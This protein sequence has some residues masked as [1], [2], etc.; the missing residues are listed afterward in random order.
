[1]PSIVQ[2][3]ELRTSIRTKARQLNPNGFAS[4]SD[5]DALI[6]EGAY[7]LYNLLVR[8]R[9]PEYFSEQWATNTTTGAADTDYVLP[10]DFFQ[11]VAIAMSD[12]PGTVDGDTVT[13][14]VGAQ[15]VEPDRFH[16]ADLAGQLSRRPAHPGDLRYSLTGTQ[17]Q[18]IEV[19]GSACL[20][21]YPAPEHVWCVR[22]VYLPILAFDGQGEA[23]DTVDGWQSYIV[24]HA[25]ADLAAQ[26]EMDPSYWLGKKAEARE[27][28]TA[29]APRRD[30]AK[31]LQVADRRGSMHGRRWPERL[32]RP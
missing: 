31:A 10:A 17:T 29:L 18:S 13:I 15:W 3:S 22:L 24:A 32:P 8:A 30:R 7:E 12:T 23:L 27:M 1:M 25:V 6:A 4:D 9:G 2:A 21:F 14:P 28:V 5:L 11:L 19:R 16:P 26:Q 20:R